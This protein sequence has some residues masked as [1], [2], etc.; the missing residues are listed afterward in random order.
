MDLFLVIQD[1][2]DPSA[3]LRVVKHCAKDSQVGP[4]GG[5]TSALLTDEKAQ[6]SAEDGVGP[7]W[8]I[9]EP[10]QERAAL[11]SKTFKECSPILRCPE[12]R[13][14]IAI[15]NARASERGLQKI[16]KVKRERSDQ[17][18]HVVERTEE[19]YVRSAGDMRKD[20]RSKREDDRA[21][22]GPEV[23]SPQIID[24]S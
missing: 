12:K 8:S 22:Q 21:G 11:S 10:N 16:K 18:Q 15:M 6:V 9:G 20:H 13:T 5:T 23:P 24:L 14:K 7:I 2:Q 4:P 1:E 17:F 3:I 19:I